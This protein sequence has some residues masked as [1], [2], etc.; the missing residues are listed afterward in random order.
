MYIKTQTSKGSKT[1]NECAHTDLEKCLKK[2]KCIFFEGESLVD[3]SPFSSQ[4]QKINFMSRGNWNKYCLKKLF[5]ACNFIIKSILRSLTCGQIYN[6]IKKSSAIFL[7]SIYT[8]YNK[9]CQFPASIYLF[10]A[11]NLNTRKT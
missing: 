8:F 7:A 6:Y 10:K 9:Y 11:N 1:T 4:I 5:Q 2:A 3:L